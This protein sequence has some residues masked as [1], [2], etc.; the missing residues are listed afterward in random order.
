MH[1]YREFGLVSDQDEVLRRAFRDGFKRAGLPFP[2][3]IE[4]LS[5][6]RDRVQ[7]QADEARLVD[8]FTTFASDGG[9]PAEHRD[10]ALDIYRTIR[11]KGP[12]AVTE[13]SPAPEVDRATLARGDELLR[14]D[15]SRYWADAELQDAIFEAQERLAASESAPAAATSTPPTG[16]DAAR[17]RVQEIDA[18][19]RDPNGD[20]QR[21]YWNDPALR[22]DYAQ[23]L[24]RLHEGTLATEHA[25]AATPAVVVPVEHASHQSTS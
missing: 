6:Y 15:P 17:Q 2:R 13:K 25:M 16:P 22:A 1:R 12:A 11:D 4:A 24:A 23:S 21:R 10:C 19:L 7:P 3:L 9:W 8:A 18:L 5:W 14:S 20:G